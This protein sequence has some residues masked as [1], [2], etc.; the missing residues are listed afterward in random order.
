MKAEHVNFS[1]FITSGK[2][3]FTIPV[4][5]R[6]YEWKEQECLKLFSDIEAI[7]SGN[8][9]HFIGTIVYVTSE[10]SNATWSEFTV[11][12]G[13]QRI[14]TL[15]LLLKAIYDLTNDEDTKSEIWDDYLTN[16]R[17]R[18]EKHRIKLKPIDSDSLTWEN[19]ITGQI[20][21]NTSSHLWK[22]YEFF[23]SK[24]TD[25]RFSPD[26]LFE[27]IQKI[28]IVYIQLETGKENP[29]VIFESINS[30]GLNL[31][32]A[33]LIRNFLL[34]NCES[35]DKQ[36]ELYKKYWIKIEAL[37]TSQVIPDFIRDYL[38]MKN[39]SLVKTGNV[40]DSF[41]QYAYTHFLSNEE[42]LLTELCRYAEYYSWFKFYQSNNKELN[43]LL[44]QFHQMKSFVAF[45]VLL[46]FFDKCYDK[47]TMTEKQLF[48]VIRILLSYQYRRLVC[49]AQYN[50]SL[51][52]N[53]LNTTYVSLPRE[54]GD[55]E[56]IPGK[57]LEILAAKTSSQTFPRDDVFKSA[58]QT[59]DLYSAKLAKYTLTMIENALNP[60]EKVA[61]TEEITIE[62][63]MP[64]KLTATWKGELGKDYEQ[65]HTQ[66]QHTIGNLTLSGSNSELG[67]IS[68]S[69]KKAIYI[70]SNISLSRDAAKEDA[71]NAKT[72]QTRASRLFDKALEIWAL[73]ERY[74]LSSDSS[75]IDYDARYN[76]MDDIKV[77]G[78]TPRSYIF[79]GD[80]NFV[81]SWRAL[82]MG[83]L[84]KL[85][86][87]D[88]ATFE[89]LIVHETFRGRHLAEPVNSEYNYR[90]KSANEICPGYYA[91]ISH[92]AQDLMSFTQIAVELY[93]FEEYI[94][95]TFKRP[96]SKPNL[97]RVTNTD[98]EIEQ[99][100]KN[101]FV[102]SDKSEGTATQYATIL[103][104]TL[105]TTLDA[106][107]VAN[108]NLFVYTTSEDFETIK[109]LL[110]ALP[111]YID[112][113]QKK[114]NSFSAAL[115][116]YSKFL[117]AEEEAVTV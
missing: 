106:H 88:S 21:N 45:E 30:T 60:R 18:E 64:Q 58:F 104:G 62:H 69:D 28:D 10:N 48:D 14:T 44:L 29:Q 91:E 27:A 32:P 25:S 80:E 23:K 6:N 12:D 59:F 100:F 63:I 20:P 15:M 61:L 26:D 52:T 7:A 67:N 41:K 81:D 5:Q 11:I 83:V 36:T 34:M 90:R 68:F 46:W 9:S 79:D 98:G 22:N 105:V 78:Q 89:K 55:A 108:P 96:S 103:S 51:S 109:D 40:Y 115:K 53:A 2:K 72:I 49:K 3:T 19:V 114:H 57:L 65:I 75:A 95:F 31:T 50:F 13:Q 112:I 113:N 47:H 38:T 110:T 101:W 35:Q 87:F 66:W 116:A 77:T 102:A 39:G 1:Y 93:G 84:N 71:W 17:A 94:E 56:D 4:Y 92:S 76:I 82:F 73:P 117:I 24:V 85:Y 33:D 43:S 54:I 99:D 74:N 107:N 86:E 16:K 42:G 37:L 70:N 8:K 97:N 111:N